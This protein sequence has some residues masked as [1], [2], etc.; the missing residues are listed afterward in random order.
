MIDDKILAFALPQCTQIYKYN[1]IP[2]Q[3]LHILHFEIK[4]NNTAISVGNDF[5]SYEC[6]KRNVEEIEHVHF[7]TLFLE[8]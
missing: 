1:A 4:T 5:N 2:Y 8:P 6:L 3:I 7:T